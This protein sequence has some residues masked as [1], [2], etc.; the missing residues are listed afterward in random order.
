MGG[1]LGV[2]TQESVAPKQSNRQQNPKTASTKKN[3]EAV[4]DFTENVDLKV[5]IDLKNVG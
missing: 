4:A 2:R 1:N 3:L 5:Q